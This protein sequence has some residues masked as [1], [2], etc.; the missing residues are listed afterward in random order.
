MEFKVK[1]F[2]NMLLPKFTIF[3]KCAGRV[4]WRAV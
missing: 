4:F 1:K 2:L 3:C